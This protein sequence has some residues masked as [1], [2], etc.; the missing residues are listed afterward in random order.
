L[1]GDNKEGVMAIRYGVDFSAGWPDIDAMTRAGRDF[2]IRYVSHPGNPKNITAA[3]AT[4]WRQHGID[5]AIVFESA[6]GRAVVG[7]AAG[8]A[9]ACA[10]REQV[11][12]AGG[13]DDGGVIYF[14]VD[15]DTTT[16]A[17]RDALDQYLTGAA[18]VLG[19]DQVGV[20]GEYEVVDYVAAHT[21]C[22]W[23]WQT[24]AWSGGKGPHSRAQL[25]QYRNGQQLG[26]ADVD[27]DR[28]LADHFGQWAT[29]KEPSMSL[30]ADEHKWLQAVYR[31]VT[32]AIGFG[33]LDFQ[34]TIK[35]VLGT[36]QTLV[37]LSGSNT[38]VLGRA[39]AS[40]EQAVLAAIAALP[41]AHLTIAEQQQVAHAAA[42]KLAE[43]GLR[44]D[45]TVL[46]DALSTDLSAAEST[47]AAGQ[48]R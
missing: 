20:Y 5:I 48:R 12:A 23:Y 47:A 14:A 28:A 1:T 26:G 8:A 32:G 42:G 34:G 18:G 16:Q 38:S 39:I 11:V 45:D 35:A 21:P 15:I 7:A 22:Q 43:H 3:E 44:L 19:W 37:N 24:Y 17:Q 2:V 27:F 13:P 31:Q 41:T 46:L 33:Q 40:T 4:H 6:A 9:D 30:T 10:A 29:G 36:V 25:Y